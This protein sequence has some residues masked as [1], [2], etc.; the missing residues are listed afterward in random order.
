MNSGALGAGAKLGPY[1]IISPLGAGGMGEVYLAKDTRLDRTVAIKVLPPHVAGN[2]DLKTRF[3]REAKA[4]SSLNHPNICSLYDIGN[5]EGIDY[6]VMEH[7][8]GET[9]AARLERGPL[10][11][12]E[13]MTYAIQIADALDKAHRQGLV[14]RDLKTLNIMLTKNGAKLLDFGLAK[15]QLSGVVNG[16]TGATH[17]TPLTGQGTIV[18]T[19]QYMAPEQL[20]GKEADSRSDI[21]SFGVVLYEMVTGKKPFAGPSQASLIASIMK[22]EPRSVTDY[23]PDISPALVRV[24]KQCLSKDPDER[25]QNAR[26][27]LHQLKWINEGG[28]LAG[29]PAPVA[30]RRKANMQ[31]AWVLTALFGVAAVILSILHFGQTKEAPRLARFAIEA[32]PGIRSMNWPV[33]SPDGSM[34]AFH[35]VDTSGRTKIWVRQMDALK[36]EPL[37]GTDGARRPF[38]SPDSKQLA[39]IRDGQ[40]MKIAA[41]G[42]PVQLIAKMPGDAA[43]GSWGSKDVILM[44]GSEID[45]I[46]KVKA[47]GGL[48]SE[49]VPAKQDTNWAG[50]AWPEF[51]PDGEH[52]LYL[53]LSFGAA[54]GAKEGHNVML[55][56]L[57]G[58]EPESLF[59]ANGKAMYDPSGYILAVDGQILSARKFDP[60]DPK[61]IGEPMPIAEVMPVGMSG[62]AD[63]SFSSNGTLVYAPSARTSGTELVWLD[64]SGRLIDTIATGKQ[65]RDI[66]LSPDGTRL[67]YGANDPVSGTDDIWTID[68]NRR[69]SMRA[70]F[71]K[72]MDM[73]P[74]WAPDG[75]SLIYT[76]QAG[77]WN[78]HRKKMSVDGDGE[79]FIKLDETGA[80]GLSAGNW[81]SR[82]GA[83]SVVR[84]QKAGEHTDI[85]LCYP[86]T[87][88][89]FEWIATTPFWELNPTFSPD[90]RFLAYTS[91][92]SGT[93]QLYV[94]QLDGNGDKW[95][96]TTESASMPVWRKDGKE[97]FYRNRNN[98]IKAISVTLGP[99]LQ[100]GA[101]TTLFE[102]LIEMS[103]NPD[104]RFDVSADGQRFVVNRIATAG[105]RPSFVLVQNWTAALT[106]K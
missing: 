39:F 102:T 51:L 43:D 92:E 9:L 106:A 78:L 16:M 93:R 44:D 36:A 50:V 12:S 80:G 52:F 75:N 71:S 76:S 53:K 62:K 104:K 86:G 13:A 31:I 83:L 46:F 34:L 64:R 77:K 67:V 42:G 8:Q 11:V 55:G 73:W 91:D 48:V 84:Q 3:E 40:L 37:A 65:F 30:A 33:L 27:L 66:S 2:P 95:Q 100:V 89:R 26:D 63:Y 69:V 98:E 49:A 5:Q 41:R 10:P 58:G 97:L 14:H 29:I 59:I 87:P 60:D 70:T 105:E 19:L 4:I 96:M 35:A 32:D 81:S 23:Q 101:T 57:S 47:S 79:P 15:L 38:W 72:E 94:R 22:E 88:S 6:L 28:S 90:G 74:I 82:D 7:L 54:D 25:W 61:N 21:F 17:S 99:T 45:P 18:G 24:V 56:S 68:L 85:G 103:A 20:E 1:E